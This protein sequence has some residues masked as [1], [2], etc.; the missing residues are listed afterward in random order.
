[1][2]AKKGIMD[3]EEDKDEGENLDL[4]DIEEGPGP[5]EY[6]PSATIGAGGMD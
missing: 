5:G 3:I 2:N 6:I 1:M 4:N